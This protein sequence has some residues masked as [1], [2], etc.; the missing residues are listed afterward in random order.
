M[1]S[2]RMHTYIHTHIHTCIHTCIHTQVL[3]AMPPRR[4]IHTYIHTYTGFG[5]NASKVN[6]ASF[7]SSSTSGKRYEDRDRQT[8]VKGMDES[9]WTRFLQ[10]M[11]VI[12][13]P[14]HL[15]N[16]A[17][18]S[19]AKNLTA[20]Q[21]QQQKKN[22]DHV[23]RGGNV[24]VAAHDDRRVGVDGTQILDCKSPH[25]AGAGVG[26]GRKNE[27]GGGGVHSAGIELA[28]DDDADNA[29]RKQRN[30]DGCNSVAQYKD[31]PPPEFVL[32]PDDARTMFV[33]CV[34]KQELLVTVHN[35]HV[36][37]TVCISQ[38]HK[39]RA[40]FKSFRGIQGVL[41]RLSATEG[42]YAHFQGS[43]TGEMMF[44]TGPPMAANQGTARR[45]ASVSSMSNFGRIKSSYSASTVDAPDTYELAFYRFV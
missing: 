37:Q 11:H 24:G 16:I 27:G 29:G 22:R 38:K 32:T 15:E 5:G 41:T 7:R 19:Q 30:R 33:T 6:T 36:G 34:H 1:A 8:E 23:T 21:Q 17:Q 20:R 43:G 45:T 3:V 12:A 13:L 31:V 35:A 44:R 18:F 42:W 10:D 14:H 4:Y 28:T 25:P 9:G 40:K 39:D 26:V 2:F